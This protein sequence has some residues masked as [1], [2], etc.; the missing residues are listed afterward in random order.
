MAINPNVQVPTNTNTDNP[1]VRLPP[2]NNALVGTRVGDPV[3]TRIEVRLSV[4]VTT[5]THRF[6]PGVQEFENTTM[7]FVGET[8]DE[9]S[10]PKVGE[11]CV[12]LRDN[13]QIDN[14]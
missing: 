9:T 8:W 6:N 2:H 3:S 12:D 10:Q 1:N 11:S 5:K 13:A 7:L 4:G 14:L